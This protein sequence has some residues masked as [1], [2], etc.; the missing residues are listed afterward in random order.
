MLILI[1]VSTSRTNYNVSNLNPFLSNHKIYL[2][3]NHYQLQ[4]Q[5]PTQLPTTTTTT[6]TTTKYIKIDYIVQ[7][8]VLQFQV[9]DQEI[10]FTQLDSK[11]LTFVLTL[12]LSGFKNPD[13]QPLFPL[14]VLFTSLVVHSWRDDF[15]LL[16]VTFII[17][18]MYFLK[19]SLCLIV[20]KRI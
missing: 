8:P 7:V 5:L 20:S 15:L 9:Q 12:Q 11:D 17:R 14:S 19:L 6:T 13:L 3:P 2:Y 4:L 10:I 18:S 16:L 1:T